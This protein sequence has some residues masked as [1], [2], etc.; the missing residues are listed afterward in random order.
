M[1]SLSAPEV[2]RTSTPPD[3]LWSVEA[4]IASVYRTG[5]THNR[6][7][8]TCMIHAMLDNNKDMNPDNSIIVNM[9]LNIS[10]FEEYSGSSDLEVYEMFVTGILCWVKM[11]GLLGTKHASFQVE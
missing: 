4:E 2:K 10:S 7:L 3:K 1:Q 9:R 11:N 8:I 6:D 5:D